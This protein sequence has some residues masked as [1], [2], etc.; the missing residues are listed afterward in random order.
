MKVQFLSGFVQELIDYHKY[1]RNFFLSMLNTKL[2]TTYII[3]CVQIYPFCFNFIKIY[4]LQCLALILKIMN[5]SAIIMCCILPTEIFI[6]TLCLVC[7]KYKNSQN[8][9]L[10][11]E[12]LEP[13]GLLQGEHHNFVT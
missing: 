2:K 13:K 9:L 8:I 10:E 7:L 12:R 1:V 11:E 6:Q 5:I 4:P 3:I